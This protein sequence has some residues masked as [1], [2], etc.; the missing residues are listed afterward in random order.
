MFARARNGDENLGSQLVPT[1][2]INR[3]ST[4]KLAITKEWQAG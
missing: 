2:L 1:Y 3:A 4:P